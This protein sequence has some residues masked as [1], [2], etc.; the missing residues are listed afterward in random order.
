[1]RVGG[2]DIS[3]S[4][5]TPGVTY[6]KDE[7]VSYLSEYYQ[8]TVP[9]TSLSDETAPNSSYWKKIT[10]LPQQG[11]TEVENYN[12]YDFSETVNVDYGTVFKTRQQVYDAIAGYGEYL[13]TQGWIFDTPML[14]W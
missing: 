5:Y 9:H 2:K 12:Q 11:G 10:K 13:Q 3:P 7:V 1:M 8:C 6:H 14:I 4:E